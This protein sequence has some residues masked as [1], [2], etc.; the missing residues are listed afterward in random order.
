MMAMCNA[1]HNSNSL[2]FCLGAPRPTL[3]YYREGSLTQPILIT[4]LNDFDPTFTG[5]WP[6]NEAGSLIP[7]ECIVGFEPGNFKF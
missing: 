3:G 7:G 5:V 6:C 4:T 1:L 2:N